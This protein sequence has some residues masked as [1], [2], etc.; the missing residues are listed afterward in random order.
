MD[1]VTSVT[2]ATQAI[3]LA[4]LTGSREIQPVAPVQRARAGDLMMQPDTYEPGTADAPVP[5]VTYS[6]R[7]SAYGS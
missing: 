7:R 1:A 2:R 5:L 6:A 4:G 3:S